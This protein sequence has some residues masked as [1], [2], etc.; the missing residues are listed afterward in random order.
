MKVESINNKL[1]DASRKKFYLALTFILLSLFF[2]IFVSQFSSLY[3]INSFAASTPS[4][5]N[6]TV[7]LAYFFEPG[8]HDCDN[9]K[10][11]LKGISAKYP[12]N[13]IL[14]SFDISLSENVELAEALG[15]L[16]QMPEEERL[17]VP[18]IFLGDDYLFRDDITYDNLEKLI[19]KSMTTNTAPPWEKVK[20]KELTVQE[21]LVARFQSFGLAAVAVSGLIDGINPCAF[22]TIIFFISYLALINRKGRDILWVGGIFTLSVFLTYFL[23]G[24]GALKMITSLS[25]L[26]LVRKIFVLVTAA[27]VLI[28]GVVSLYD[29]LQFKKKGTTKDAKLQLPSFLKKMIHS[30]VRKN[31][32][33]SNYILMAAVT[34]FIVSLLEL[35]C[36]GQ[37]Y[38]PTIMFIST[39]PDLKANALFYL[40][41]YNLMF[42]VPL[43]LVFSFTYWG[44]TSAQ[45]AVLT[46]KNF[47]KVKMA[48]T[49]LFFGL[50]GLLLYSGIFY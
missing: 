15:E 22:A 40:L 8:C 13:L 16:Y 19:Q 31:V 26:P 25:F 29:Y 46:E 41:F 45:W 1:I 27:L 24:T 43:V 38:L 10:I 44:T 50:A 11:V 9:A 42:V 34:G 20:G 3:A 47:G 37:V 5:V 28:L 35:A 23:I 17:L 21:R 2:V 6:Y 7:Y 30:A 48:M 36:T 18:V 39:I 33:L 32:R 12:E 4:L 49:L 14:K